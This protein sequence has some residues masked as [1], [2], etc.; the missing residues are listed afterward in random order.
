MRKNPLLLLNIT[1]RRTTGA[2]NCSFVT[3]TAWKL[4]I[5]ALV[6]VFTFGSSA[7]RSYRDVHNVILNKDVGQEIWAPSD[8]TNTVSLS[9]SQARQQRY[10]ENLESIPDTISSRNLGESLQRGLDTMHLRKSL[11]RTRNGSYII[12]ALNQEGYHDIVSNSIH[13]SQAR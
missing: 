7:V 6:L 5:P 4:T 3:R 13:N 11:I 2:S 1:M 8:K 10:C 12:Y 9:K